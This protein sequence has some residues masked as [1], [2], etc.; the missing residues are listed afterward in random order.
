MK[1]LGRI[2]LIVLAVLLLLV[3]V[4]PFLVPV[5]PL[6]DTVPPRELAGPDSRFVL[7]DGL[8][9]HYEL[10]GQGEPALLLLHG[11]AASTFSWREV[12]DPLAE[13]AT[14][15][16]FDRP[17]FGLT[18]RPL[19]GQWQGQNPYTAEAQ[20]GLTVGL[21]D[22]LGLDRAVL[23]GN[24]AGGSVALLTALR[25]P[26]RVQALVLVDA[27]VYG[28][29][30]RFPA[31]LKPLLRTPQARRLGPLA[32]RAIQDWGLD[33]GRSAWHD[34]SRI[35]PEIWEGYTRPLQAQDWDRAL[36][37]LTVAGHDLGLDERLD[38][39]GVPVLVI[40][41]DDDRI[42]PTELSVRLAG[43][44]PGAELVVIPD[45]GHVPH[46]ECPAP[47]LEAVRAFLADL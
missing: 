8:E 29:G 26:E 24:S 32:V 9:V 38:E 40:T 47:F 35:T 22:E 1:K 19:P 5:P 31:W 41:G 28:G 30:S 45:C 7:V 17:A 37:E 3:A 14:V 10:A 2:L 42:V 18:Q 15:V 11:F 46:E 4:G 27:A 36:W 6:E 12:I 16:A 43:E 13:T 44:L 33:F 23:I 34:P 21:M 25:Y 20:A 39:V